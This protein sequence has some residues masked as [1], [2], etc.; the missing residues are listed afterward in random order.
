MEE[1]YPDGYYFIKYEDL[2][3]TPY[4]KTREI[5][6]FLR[7]TNTKN[8]DDDYSDSIPKSFQE[9]PSSIFQYFR[10]RV[11]ANLLRNAPTWSAEQNAPTWSTEQSHFP[12]YQQWRTMI[13]QDELTKVE[14]E[15]KESLDLLNY[16]IFGSVESSRNASLSL[17]EGEQEFSIM[18]DSGTDSEYIYS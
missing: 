11:Y 7:G 17:F 4:I 14:E 16:R 3:R 2:R 9:P 8:P 18:Q 6:N 10:S 13:T 15:C 1:T 5:F 12:P